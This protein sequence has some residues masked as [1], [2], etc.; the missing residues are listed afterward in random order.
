MAPNW[1]SKTFFCSNALTHWLRNNCMENAKCWDASGTLFKNSNPNS[2]NI[3][4][5]LLPEMAA[6]LDAAGNVCTM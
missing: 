3:D 5:V 2:N 6:L 4:K 1:N